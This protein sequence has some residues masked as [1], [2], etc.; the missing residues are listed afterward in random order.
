M[1]TKPAAVPIQ[2][3]I[4][5][6]TTMSP[7]ALHRWQL[8]KLFAEHL[9]FVLGLS[10]TEAVGAKFGSVQV[11]LVPPCESKATDASATRGILTEDINSWYGDNRHSDN[12]CEYQS[13]RL[14][15]NVLRII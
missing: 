13:Q 8:A 1:Q 12:A 15:C 2:V 3:T 14:S 5:S 6:A 11:A 4:L 7:V 10:S 9:R